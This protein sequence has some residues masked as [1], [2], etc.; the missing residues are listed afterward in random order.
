MWPEWKHEN[1]EEWKVCDCCHVKTATITLGVFNLVLSIWGF[2]VIVLFTVSQLG[3]ATD[4]QYQQWFILYAAVLVVVAIY[5]GS[6]IF[7]L[8]GISNRIP[9]LM[10]PFICFQ[11]FGLAASF[12]SLLNAVTVQN[13]NFV[14]AGILLLLVKYCLLKVVLACRRYLKYQKIMSSAS[15][16]DTERDQPPVYVVTAPEFQKF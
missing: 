11:I 15:L 6:T 7:L 12:F 4:V 5:I 8:V 1:P 9:A 2:F 13:G 16:R 3:S 10:V 14:A